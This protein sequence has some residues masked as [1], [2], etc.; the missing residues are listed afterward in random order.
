MS[1]VESVQSSEYLP[2]NAAARAQPA[3]VRAFQPHSLIESSDGAVELASFGYS[4]QDISD[5]LSSCGHNTEAAFGTLFTALIGS[6]Q[7]KGDRGSRSLDTT[8]VIL[9]FFITREGTGKG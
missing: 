8:H 3:A 2:T 5:A 7:S 6:F 9:A 4:S 1:F